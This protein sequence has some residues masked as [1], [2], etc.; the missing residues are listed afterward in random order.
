M[1]SP[2]TKSHT[3]PNNAWRITTRKLPIL[4]ADPIEA[5]TADVGIPIPEM[6]FGDNFAQIT[7]VPS[8]WTLN[9]NVRDALDRVSKTE[10]GMLQ[11]AVAEEWKKERS[12]QEEV[13]VVVKP[14]D[15]SYTTD[16]KG[17]TVGNGG[18]AVEGWKES[19]AA[20]DPIRTDLLSRQDP[21]LFFDEVDLMEDELADN[22]IALLSLKVRMMPARM[23][24]LQRYFLRLDG[25]IV[26]I[27]D[28][29]VYIEHDSNKVIRQ[30]TAK[31]E[32]YEVLAEELKRRR[33][34]V[35]ESFRDVN[36]ISAM[37]KTVEER[38]DVFEV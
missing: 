26:R 22:G 5:L 37:C 19:S 18:E 34:N 23:L 9:F 27:R 4:K 11:V 28:T 8:G 15:W 3:S 21:I 2:G 29:R 35:A 14:F 25:V 16:Y 36:M 17:T 7:H 38:T 32:K 6:I 12:H 1:A 33:E 13:Q 30:Y 31:E 10:E 20:Q 24:L